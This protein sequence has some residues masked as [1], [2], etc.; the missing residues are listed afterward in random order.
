MKFKEIERLAIESFSFSE[1]RVIS[2]IKENSARLGNDLFSEF[3]IAGKL[4]INLIILSDLNMFGLKEAALQAA[5]SMKQS[6]SNDAKKTA[7]TAKDR[8]TAFSE[9]LTA[10]ANKHGVLLGD[11]QVS[12]AENELRGVVFNEPQC[13]DVN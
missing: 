8:V 5:L 6:E 7:P 13:I 9:E 4:L 11:V 3:D 12:V 1:D 10:L 2:N